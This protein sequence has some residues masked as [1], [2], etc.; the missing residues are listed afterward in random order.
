MKKKFP[1]KDVGQDI[2]GVVSKMIDAKIKQE[3]K[4]WGEE[5]FRMIVKPETLEELLFMGLT[6]LE[7]TSL[8][9][10]AMIIKSPTVFPINQKELLSGYIDSF[11]LKLAWIFGKFKELGYDE[12]LNAFR[13]ALEILE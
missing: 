2:L 5:H 9:I 6:D 7:E 13:V 3:E 1:I 12:N 10:R 8:R 11:F 4:Y